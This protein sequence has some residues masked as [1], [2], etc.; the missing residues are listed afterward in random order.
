MFFGSETPFESELFL[1]NYLKHIN[2][3]SITHYHLN[4]FQIV[5]EHFN[6]ENYLL[7]FKRTT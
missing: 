7:Y 6:Y 1:V 3:L 5:I 2:D 4:C